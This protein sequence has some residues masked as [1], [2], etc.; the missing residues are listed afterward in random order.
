MLDTCGLMMEYRIQVIVSLYAH[1]RSTSFVFVL[2]VF[3]FWFLGGFFEV[4]P[5]WRRFWVETR[6]QPFSLFFQALT[7]R[8]ATYSLLVVETL[9]SDSQSFT[10]FVN[11]FYF[12]FA[13]TRYQHRFMIRTELR[14][15]NLSSFGNSKN[16]TPDM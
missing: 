10:K 12:R 13:F 9:S 14:T 16:F 8:L 3:R 4:S 6:F 15:F 5:C 1:P 11:L 2:W 7:P